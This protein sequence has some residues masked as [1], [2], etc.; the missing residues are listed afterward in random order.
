MATTGAAWPDGAPETVAATEIG[1]AN[2]LMAA[3]WC[4]AH[5]DDYQQAHDCCVRALA[6]YRQHP[7]SEGQAATLHNLGYV[8][9]STGEHAKAADYFEQSLVIFRQLGNS[10]SEANILD[11]LGQTFAALADHQ[12]ARTAWR[13]ALDLVARIQARLDL[14]LS[15]QDQRGAKSATADREAGPLPAASRQP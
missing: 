14:C 11:Q 1:R 15:G 3:G 12:R 10:Y 6:L 8:A 7:V 2:A 4:H 9:Q 13:R 5:L